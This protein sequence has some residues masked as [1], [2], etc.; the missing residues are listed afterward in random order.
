MFGADIS[1]RAELKAV[2]PER[3][4]RVKPITKSKIDKEKNQ[5]VSF[6]GEGDAI[7]KFYHVLKYKHAVRGGLGAKGGGASEGGVGTSSASVMLG[8][9]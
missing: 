2:H 3:V 9:S 6:P 8:M 4:S 7:I 1:R 5:P